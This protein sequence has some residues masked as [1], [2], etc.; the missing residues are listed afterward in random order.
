MYILHEAS[1]DKFAV[2]AELILE[3]N[4]KHLNTLKRFRKYCEYT[5]KELSAQSGVALRMIQ[6]Y[7]QG[8]NDLHKASADTVTAL[9]GALKCRPEELLE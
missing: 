6:L 4:R 8:Q 5:Q 7:E 1:E 2:E 9:A 3:E